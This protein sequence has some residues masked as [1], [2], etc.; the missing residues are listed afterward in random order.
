MVP[1][2]STSRAAAVAALFVVLAATRPAQGASAAPQP[3]A[4]AA[5]DLTLTDVFYPGL[6]GFPCFR[7]PALI[8]GVAPR[9]LLAVAE[10]R[11][12]SCGDFGG[13]HDLVLRRSADGGST[14]GSLQVVVSVDKPPFASGDALWNPCIV[15][16]T[17]RSSPSSHGQA[18]VI[19]ATDDIVMTFNRAPAALNNPSSLMS[20]PYARESFV[21]RS[22]DDGAT[23]TAPTNITA[24]VQSREWVYNAYGPGR[25]IRV[26]APGGV[27]VR[28]ALPDP[29]A[30]PAEAVLADP[31]PAGALVAPGYH[32][33]V[34]N[35]HRTGANS[36]YHAHATVSLDGGYT[37]AVAGSVGAGT[38]EGQLAEVLPSPDARGPLSA[39]SAAA[40][41]SE[42]VFNM[43][44]YQS[45]H[46]S[47]S[48]TTG[49][50]GTAAPAHCRAVSRSSGGATDL[51]WSPPQGDPA[52]V[53]PVCQASMIRDTVSDGGA[54][55]TLLF[56]NPSN[57]GARVNMTLRVS[58]DGGLTW[59]EASTRV[60]W[61]AGSGYSSLAVVA[62][63]AGT[64]AAPTTV[65]CLF[66]KIYGDT[67]N[68][69]VASLPLPTAF[70]NGV[71][72][73]PA[74]EAHAPEPSDQHLPRASPSL[75]TQTW[76]V[77]PIGGIPTARFDVAKY[78]AVGDGVTLNTAAFTK[79]VAA[80]AASPSGGIVVVPAGRWLTGGIS[81]LSGVFLQVMDGATVLGSDR[82][83]DYPYSPGDWVVVAAT[84]ATRVGILGPGTID[85]QAV[86]NFVDYYNASDDRLQPKTWSGQHGCIGE[87]RPRLVQFT[88]CSD[89]TLRGV[90]LTNSPDWTLHF[91]G[92]R[93]VLVDGISSLGNRQW[94]NND[95]CD[96]DSS[97]DVTVVD[98]N[99]SV[100]DDGVCPK[101]SAGYGPMSDLLVRNV[102]IRSKS[103]AIK[104]G[105]N[106]D[107]PMHSILFD[108]ITIW[109]SNR[110]LGIQQRS[111]GDVFNVTY[112]NINIE[113]RFVAPR[114][115]GSGEPIWISTLQRAATTPVGRTYGITFVNISARSENGAFVSGLANTVA[116]VT[117]DNVHITVDKWSNYSEPV[118]DYRPTGTGSHV[119]DKV[120]GPVDGFYLEA[121][122]GVSFAGSSVTYVDR[123][124]Q[125]WWGECYVCNATAGCAH[126]PHKLPP[127]DLLACSPPPQTARA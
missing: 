116:N 5:Y 29:V 77:L 55:P 3:G 66:E 127:R 27:R 44:N 70:S 115:W 43:R 112:S 67:M 35:T 123:D 63:P 42:L 21:V 68:L 100:A 124:A 17:D 59:P 106:T 54:S 118:H 72:D 85:G 62:P 108:N 92:C 4:G 95:G 93:R 52:L 126:A 40:G 69:T 64:V 37:W 25:A 51:D 20:N 57:T 60:L 79:A 121:V 38:N 14:W 49:T 111:M 34:G 36:T 46:S 73:R 83:D 80:A 31:L 7:I 13:P 122:D 117:F 26:T 65:A 58:T 98:S 75:A 76:P 82:I 61:S 114:W 74:G 120:V 99:I 24:Q 50:A 91:L 110:G 105:S 16:D 47:G 39:G 1:V 84:N 22:H 109:D 94:P 30:Q 33:L 2:R 6:G 87:C 41:V 56:S 19:L 125:P 78:G 32:G 53:E 11:R 119:A 96:P 86:P 15:A 48:G 10:G 107:T 104:F 23:W 45:C 88:S 18:G 97:V 12:G 81:L 90:T 113:T 71:P 89:V 9:S 28:A 101:A 8:E 102:T 103:G